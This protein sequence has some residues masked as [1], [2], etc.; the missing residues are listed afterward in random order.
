MLYTTASAPKP[1][2]G[3]TAEHQALGLWIRAE[4]LAHF[5]DRGAVGAT[6]ALEGVTAARDGEVVAFRGLRLLRRAITGEALASAASRL[7]QVPAVAAVAATLRIR[8]LS[9]GLCGVRS[10]FFH[11]VAARAESWDNGRLSAAALGVS[12]DVLAVDKDCIGASSATLSGRSSPLERW[13]GDLQAAGEAS[14]ASTASGALPPVDM[15]IL[16]EIYSLRGCASPMPEAGGCFGGGDQASATGAAAP[17]GPSDGPVE[18]DTPERKSSGSRNQPLQAEMAPMTTERA[19]AATA[20][21]PSSPSTESASSPSSSQARKPEEPWA[22]LAEPRS[23]QSSAASTFAWLAKKP[24]SATA[25][26]HSARAASP[27]PSETRGR[28]AARGP[29]ELPDGAPA[30]PSA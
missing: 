11:M 14:S 7:A 15:E 23:P 5:G 12:R 2:L 22:T 10:L 27:E 9:R 20:S 18:A 29:E 25:F 28:R 13:H 24:A 17:R 16:E 1:T 3:S 26:P 8:Q 19:S 6:A 21:R 30:S 4:L